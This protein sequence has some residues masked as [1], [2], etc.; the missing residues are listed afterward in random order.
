LK[1]KL[2]LV[3]SLVFITSTFF[4][5]C[6]KND[7]KEGSSSDKETTFEFWT[8]QEL[9]KSFMDDAAE[10]WNKENE[11]QIVSI[12]TNVY[13]Y[14]EM[15]DKLLVSLQSGTGAPDIADIEIGKFANYLKG[16]KPQLVPLN[17]VLEPEIDNFIVSRLD[18]YAKDGKYYGLDY[19][20]GATVMYYNTEITDEAGINIDE[21]LTWDDYV[22]AGKTV[23]EKTKI[24]MTTCETTEY[25][26]FY[27]MI[28]QQGSDF[29]DENGEV[30]MDNEENIKAL[31]FIYD[32]VNTSKIAV[33]T[34]GDFHH[35][36]EYYAFMNKGGAASV[37][38][39]IWYMGRFLDYMP[40]LK[41]KIAIRPMP[42]WEEGGKRSAGMGGTGT[43]ITNQAENQDLA[44]EFLGYAKASEEGAIKTW[45]VLGFDPIR[46]DVWDAP[47]MSEENKYTEYFGTEIFSTLET[48]KDDINPINAKEK[49]PKAI[50]LFNKTVLFK[51][52]DEKSA[53]AE[54]ALKEVAEELRNK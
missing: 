28:S 38:M 21:I 30:T 47:E 17:D 10:S 22:E 40:D 6:N 44:V 5:G 42:A 25:W 23:M 51:V 52:L 18:N 33:T 36:E 48:I 54:E 3:L 14:D 35:S 50:S 29:L 31:Q 19:H 34:P 45:T 32:M 15:H 16:S 9:H 43:A 2:A 1:K 24:P 26:T 41:G 49:F 27:P 8:F 4:Y 20:V 39:P 46:W 12:K 11:D 13:P 7:E 37:M 53:T